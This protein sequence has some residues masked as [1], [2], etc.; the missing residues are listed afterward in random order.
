MGISCCSLSFSSTHAKGFSALANALTDYVFYNFFKEHKNVLDF[1]GLNYYSHG[2]V[3]N[4]P[5]PVR[6]E[7]E[8]PTNNPR[9]SIS[10]E[11]LYRA[12]HTIAD[13][14]AKPLNIPIYITENG[15]G[16]GDNNEMRTLFLKRYLYAISHAIQEDGLDIR[17][18]FHWSF[19]DNYEWGTYK[20]GYGFY[21]IDRTIDETTGT[22]RLTRSLRPSA[23][24]FIDAASAYREQY[25]A[26]RQI[27]RSGSK[28]T[29]Y[30]L[31][32]QS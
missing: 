26:S 1:I 21:A 27:N 4:G 18:Y 17:G 32:Q 28:K 24:P 8:L 9:N 14:I 5:K 11:G 25:E 3:K 19:M 20:S 7:T 12:L 31:S 10:A 23:Q 15:I 22:P 30:R 6:D 29:P 16:A 13:K 2:I